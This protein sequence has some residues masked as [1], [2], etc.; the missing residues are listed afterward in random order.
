[1]GK[2]ELEGK[3][4]EFRWA[5]NEMFGIKEVAEGRV[6]GVSMGSNP[7]G[8]PGN[9]HNPPISQGFKALPQNSQPSQ[10]KKPQAFMPSKPVN[11]YQAAQTVHH[12][13]QPA[14]AFRNLFE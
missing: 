7:L 8:N 10:P 6:G 2:G 4:Q 12:A 9:T 5:V 1:M 13:S 14:N 3:L 11:T